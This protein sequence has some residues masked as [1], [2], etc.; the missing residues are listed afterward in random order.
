[1][2]KR[3]EY[4]YRMVS[5]MAVAGMVLVGGVGC[6]TDQMSPTPM[7]TGSQGPS[8]GFP[9]ATD[10]PE[11]VDVG[12]SSVPPT[13]ITDFGKIAADLP[14]DQRQVIEQNLTIMLQLNGACAGQPVM[15]AI[16][17]GGS[18][19]HW[20]N[21]P[22]DIYDTSFLVDIPS[23]RQTYHVDSSWIPKNYQ[24]KL[25]DGFT[26]ISCPGP[27]QLIYDPFACV[28]PPGSTP[29]L[30]SP[31]PTRTPTAGDPVWAAA[32]EFSRALFTTN[33]GQTVA[34]DGLIAAVRTSAVI[35]GGPATLVEG[36]KRVD[37]LT[38]VTHPAC[39]MTSIADVTP[40]SMAAD[41]DYPKVDEIYV[42]ATV[43]CGDKTINVYVDLG[44]YDKKISY[45]AI[46]NEAVSLVS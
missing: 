12:S 25:G 41:P 43:M 1:M 38:G 30:A 40:S 45:A 10:C 23:L 26:Q 31:G 27:G 17:R 32:Q 19:E 8:V 42:L 7:V 24:P 21:E 14:E 18:Y 36:L 11:I 22:D 3:A 13:I 29:E 44:T 46:P 34:Q 15:D 5:V 4:S 35:A 28:S 9:S 33:A 39:A 2:K 20:W 6:S 16:V 37:E